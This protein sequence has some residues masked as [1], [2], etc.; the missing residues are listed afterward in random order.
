MSIEATT[1]WNDYSVGVT[2]RRVVLYDE[3]QIVCL[4]SA[5]VTPTELGT[6]QRAKHL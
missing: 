1:A 2:F 5:Q 6:L 4:D 3:N